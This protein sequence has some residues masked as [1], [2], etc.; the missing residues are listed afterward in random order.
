MSILANGRCFENKPDKWLI[1]REEELLQYDMT[2]CTAGVY[3][4]SSVVK[5]KPRCCVF[6]RRPEIDYQ[7][8][9]ML[10]VP[11]G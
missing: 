8:R 4:T 3:G 6:V 7:T 10:K 1:C 11:L 5:N 2:F 9:F